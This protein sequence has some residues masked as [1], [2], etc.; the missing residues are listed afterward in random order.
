[1]E[2]NSDALG[3]FPPDLIPPAEAQ[4]D[5]ADRGHA[6]AEAERRDVAPVRRDEEGTRDGRADQGRECDEEE[7][8]PGAEPG[9]EEREG[10]RGGGVSFGSFPRSGWEQRR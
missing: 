2:G 10:G 7:A 8:D 6:A 9:R 3:A 1:M 4:E 5:G